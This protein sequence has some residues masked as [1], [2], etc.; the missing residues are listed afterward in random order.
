MITVYMAKKTC[1]WRR[2]FGVLSKVV[3]LYVRKLLYYPVESRHLVLPKGIVIAVT[4]NMT[5]E[6][7]LQ[8][9]LQ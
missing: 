5:K 4:R 8:Q 9:V 2:P 6:K 1:Q 7:I 3:N